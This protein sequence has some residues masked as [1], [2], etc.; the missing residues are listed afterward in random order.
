MTASVED[1]HK[2]ETDARRSVDQAEDD[3]LAGKRSVT[4]A[5][6]HKITDAAR[7]AALSAEAA[8]QRAEQDRANARLEG[9]EAV[10]AEVVNLAASEYP[11]GLAEA[12]A[13]IADACARAQSI[14]SAHDADIAELTAA[15]KRLGAEHAAPGGPRKTSAF[16][17]L[18]GNGITLKD[19][20]VSP[21]GGRIGAAITHAIR[22]DAERAAAEVR[23]VRETVPAKR[24][25]HVLRQVSNGLLFPVHGDLNQFQLA[26]L[27]KGEMTELSAAEIDLWMKGEL[28]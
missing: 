1:A 18:T 11:P 20:T 10:A 15:A 3:I 14:A 26:K 28:A 4:A 9:L 2:T 7:H 13:D 27:R 22:G 17:A 6:L 19:K 8:R 23:T 5:A 12:F 25:G 24:P 16:L 21:V